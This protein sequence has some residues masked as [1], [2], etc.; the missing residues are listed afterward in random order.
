VAWCLGLAVLGYFW[1][2]SVFNRDPK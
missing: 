1:S 2:K